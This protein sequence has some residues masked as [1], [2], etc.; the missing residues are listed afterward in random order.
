M[1]YLEALD[2]FIKYVLDEYADVVDQHN[3]EPIF[4]V[5]ILARDFSE[6]HIIINRATGVEISNGCTQSM[7][8]TLEKSLHGKNPI[9]RAMILLT[10]APHMQDKTV[11]AF[12]K[13]ELLFDKSKVVCETML[14]I[15]SFEKLMITQ[16]RHKNL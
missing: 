8:A 5:P 2:A 16:R 4:A 11:R 9:T 10:L 12:V 13:Q 1:T 7:L 15:Y 6:A 14:R 3:V